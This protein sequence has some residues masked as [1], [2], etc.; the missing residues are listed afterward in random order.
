VIFIVTGCTSLPLVPTGTEVTYTHKVKDVMGSTIELYDETKTLVN[1]T[2]EVMVWSINGEHYIEGRT[3]V[4]GRYLQADILSGKSKLSKRDKWNAKS[5][6][7]LKLGNKSTFKYG[8]FVKS[9]LFGRSTE[10]CE[11]TGREDY[12]LS[13]KTYNAYQVNCYKKGF[14]SG[15]VFSTRYLFHPD[16]PVFLERKTGT[17]SRD[18][19][20]TLQQFVPSIGE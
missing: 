17:W 16:I 5:L 9:I 1:D 11:V 13:G 7:P 12:I 4:R 10:T 3:V 15:F 14:L 20:Y 19:T 2:S 6:W 8:S 18:T